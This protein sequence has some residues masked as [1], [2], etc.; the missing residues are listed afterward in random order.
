MAVNG[1]KLGQPARDLRLEILKGLQF[2]LGPGYTRLEI[3]KGLLEFP[4]LF[5]PELLLLGGRFLQ[6]GSA[7]PRYLKLGLQPGYFFS[8]LQ[9]LGLVV[10]R[11]GF[12][13]GCAEITMSE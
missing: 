2:T 1:G 4:S 6:L 11:R 3:L 13:L 8:L 7:T 10:V 12:L 9:E 5:V